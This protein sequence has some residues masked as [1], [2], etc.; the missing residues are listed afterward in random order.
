VQ[1]PHGAAFGVGQIQ[2][3]GGSDPLPAEASVEPASGPVGTQFTIF[4]PQGRMQ[5]TDVC[6]LYPDGESTDVITPTRVTGTIP[7][8]SLGDH[9]FRVA[10]SRYSNPRF[11]DLAFLVEA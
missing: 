8:V 7:A 1:P 9:F 5:P 3:K 10:E 6:I 2:I 4:D 11:P